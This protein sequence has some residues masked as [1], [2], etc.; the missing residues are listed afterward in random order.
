MVYVANSNSPVLSP[1]QSRSSLSSLSFL[2]APPKPPSFFLPILL[3][4]FELIA[5]FAQSLWEYHV[6]WW[7]S[8][9]HVLADAFFFFFS[10][11]V[12][13]VQDLAGGRR[14]GRR[15][16]AGTEYESIDQS[17]NQSDMVA[18]GGRTCGLEVLYS[19]SAKSNFI[20]L[21]FPIVRYSFRSQSKRLF[22]N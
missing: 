11:W 8:S 19:K 2:P 20:N 18:D 1:P 10:E 7:Y 17:I 15:G 22:R 5:N 13:A 12:I 14:H 9:G 16:S 6:Y 4:V 21:E 3:S